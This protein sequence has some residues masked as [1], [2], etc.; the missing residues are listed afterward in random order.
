MDV[1]LRIKTKTVNQTLEKLIKNMMTFNVVKLYRAFIEKYRFAK[2][3]PYMFPPGQFAEKLALAIKE[4]QKNE[5]FVICNVNIDNLTDLNQSHGFNNM[6]K[7]LKIIEERICYLCGTSGIVSRISNGEILL[8]LR[9]VHSLDDIVPMLR[10]LKN[11]IT[12][13]RHDDKKHLALTASIG[14]S[15]YPIEGIKAEILIRHA[16]LAM[17]SAKQSGKNRYEIYDSQSAFVEKNKFHKCELLRQAIVNKELEL[18]YQPKI[19]LGNSKILGM[20][21]LIRWKHPVKGLLEP[22][23]FLPESISNGLGYELGLWVVESAASQIHEWNLQGINLC[24]SVNISGAQIIHKSFL[25]DVNKI[26]HKYHSVTPQM[27]EFEILESDAIDDVDR[28]TEAIQSYKTLGFKFSLDDFGTGYS[29][30]LHLK[31]FPAEYVKIDKAFVNGIAK[32]EKDKELLETIIKLSHTFNFQVIAE[33]VES[34][35]QQQILQDMGCK[36]AQG[37]FISRPIAASDVTSWV[38]SYLINHIK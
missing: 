17:Y 27:L 35:Q 1:N 30:L 18:Y 25:P 13:V 16:N 15:I 6:N 24:V 8:L 5:V 28:L 10:H 21:A 11:S 33:G 12:N 31:A 26:L 3:I 34:G 36:Y 23:A 4:S 29:S 14:A 37:Y 22:A 2:S 38:K 7:V 32:N 19:D 20:E 9:P